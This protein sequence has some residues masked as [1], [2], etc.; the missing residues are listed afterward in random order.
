MPKSSPLRRNS[1]GRCARTAWTRCCKPRVPRTSSRPSFSRCRPS[2]ATPISDIIEGP[3]K[4]ANAAH[5]DL[6]IDPLLVNALVAQ[7]DGRGCAAAFGIRPATAPRRQPL[8]ATA[9]LTLSSFEAA[10]GMEGVLAKQLKAAQHA[11]GGGSGSTAPAVRAEPLHLG[12]GRKS[13]RRKALHGAS[14]GYYQRHS[15]QILR[16]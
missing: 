2:R 12:C 16:R 1:S 14:G 5:M 9:K 8:G 15:L 13:A 4:V 10:G 7:A 3:L 11:G 6:E